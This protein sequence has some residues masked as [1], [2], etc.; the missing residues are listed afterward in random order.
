MVVKSAE[1]M[2]QYGRG[3]GGLCR[4]AAEHWFQE[5]KVAIE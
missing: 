3:D 4:W 2:H 5:L 1:L